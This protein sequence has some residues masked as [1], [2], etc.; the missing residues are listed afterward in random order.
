MLRK[1]Q[2]R[3]YPER[4]VEVGGKG[5]QRFLHTGTYFAARPPLT[6]KTYD[7][8]TLSRLRAD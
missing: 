5:G 4:D 8:G 7:L 3:D 2:A 1:R 6:P